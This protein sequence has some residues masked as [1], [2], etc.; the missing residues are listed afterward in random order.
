MTAARLLLC[1]ALLPAL[2]VQGDGGAVL[3]AHTLVLTTPATS[4]TDYRVEGLHT[5]HETLVN[6][7]GQAWTG[8]TVQLVREMGAG[9]RPLPVVPAD[10][11]T[12]MGNEIEAA[13]R[14]SVEVRIDGLYLGLP[15]GS[16]TLSR[17]PDADSLT[18]RF[19][20]LPVQPGQRIDLRLRVNCLSDVLSWRLAYTPQFDSPPAR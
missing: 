15:G 6:D 8:L 11:T 7:S 20:E 17:S 19:V 12:F 1:L 14:S 13:W 4:Y 16:W 9:R 3:L 10:A 18:I 2:P 5:L